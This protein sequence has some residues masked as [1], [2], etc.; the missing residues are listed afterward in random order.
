VTFYLGSYAILVKM[1]LIAHSSDGKTGF[2]AAQKP[3][4]PEA[5]KSLYLS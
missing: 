2:Q 1:N 5:R 3:D 4:S